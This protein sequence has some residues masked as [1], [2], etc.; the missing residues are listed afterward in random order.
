MVALPS[1]PFPWLGWCDARHVFRHELAG[2]GSDARSTV[3]VG[4]WPRDVAASTRSFVGMADSP[5]L[6]AGDPAVG[7]REHDDGCNVYGCNVCRASGRHHYPRQVTARR[8]RALASWCSQAA[9]GCRR[10]VLRGWGPLIGAWRWCQI[11]QMCLAGD[12]VPRGGGD[13]R[14]NRRPSPCLADRRRLHLGHESRQ[15]DYSAL[16]LGNYLRILMGRC[17][18]GATQGGLGLVLSP[19]GAAGRMVTPIC[20]TLQLQ[21]R[22]RCYCGDGGWSWRIRMSQRWSGASLGGSDPARWT[23]QLVP[24]VRCLCRGGGWTHWI[25]LSRWR[26]SLVPVGGGTDQAEEPIEYACMEDDGSWSIADSVHAWAGARWDV[27]R[28]R[29]AWPVGADGAGPPVQMHHHGDAARKGGGYRAWNRRDVASPEAPRARA[30]GRCFSSRFLCP[31]RGDHTGRGPSLGKWTLYV[32]WNHVCVSGSEIAWCANQGVVVRGESSQAEQW[33]PTQTIASSLR[34]QRLAAVWSKSQLCDAGRCPE[35]HPRRPFA[36]AASGYQWPVPTS[37]VSSGQGASVVALTPF[38]PYGP[39]QRGLRQYPAAECAWRRPLCFYLLLLRGRD[40]ISDCECPR[41]HLTCWFDGFDDRELPLAGCPG[42]WQLREDGSAAGQSASWRRHDASRAQLGLTTHHFEC[43][44]GYPGAAARPGERV[45]CSGSLR[46]Q[47]GLCAR[48]RFPDSV[49]P[50][51]ETQGKSRVDPPRGSDPAWGSGSQLARRGYGQG[52][53]RPPRHSEQR[54]GS[55]FAAS[56]VL[57]VLGFLI[58][59]SHVHGDGLTV[60]LATLISDAQPYEAEGVVH[61]GHRFVRLRTIFGARIACGRRWPRQRRSERS[62]AA[63]QGACLYIASQP[64]RHGGWRTTAI[65][66]TTS[67]FPCGQGSVVKEYTNG[68]TF[69][70]SYPHD[71][72]PEVSCRRNRSD[73]PRLPSGHRGDP[74]PH[75]CYIAEGDG[76]RVEG[77]CHLLRLRGGGGPPALGAGVARWLDDD[78]DLRQWEE[79]ELARRTS[80]MA[81]LATH[82]Q[83]PCSANVIVTGSVQG[84]SIAVCDGCFR[85]IPLSPPRCWRCGCGAYRCGACGLDECQVCERPSWTMVVADAA[86]VTGDQY[87][88]EHMNMTD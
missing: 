88:W 9:A 73:V 69:T 45:S 85:D 58:F 64:L 14:W 46:D 62:A 17:S 55:G 70:S 34:S 68:D 54:V 2:D 50:L 11:S 79:S 44:N 3:S 39:I 8:G 27:E 12:A 31:G 41:R 42:I 63:F 77:P 47:G 15:A 66:R 56:N 82:V 43:D 10:R 30:T 5:Y 84:V 16:N 86:D 51:W 19:T 38:L 33:R 67:L 49:D 13:W 59:C 23:S 80:E 35:P 28:G 6:G 29:S 52:P 87:E 71:H 36:T 24:C 81:M 61:S 48:W 65:W 26:W 25:R 1:A 32:F 72:A 60:Y 57:E 76:V 37:A 20:W 4:G 21:P 53:K 78:D 83:P 74:A 22:G 75:R 7:W 40:V 18:N